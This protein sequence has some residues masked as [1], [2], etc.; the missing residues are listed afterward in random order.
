M[1]CQEQLPK[2]AAEYTCRWRSEVACTAASTGSY[3]SDWAYVLGWHGAIVLPPP[4]AASAS[5]RGRHLHRLKLAAQRCNFCLLRLHALLLYAG[6]LRLHQEISTC[7]ASWGLPVQQQ[8]VRARASHLHRLQLAAQ[9]SAFSL[10]RSH[11][12]LAMP[13]CFGCT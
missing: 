3:L 8:S 5:A 12:L 9:H 2:A 1:R 11:T 4:T 6:L 7:S 13:A 10:L